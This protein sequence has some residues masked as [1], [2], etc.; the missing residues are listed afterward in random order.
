MPRVDPYDASAVIHPIARRDPAKVLLVED[1][2]TQLDMS[3]RALTRRGYDVT[4]VGSADAARAK[5]ESLTPDIILL[6][7]FLPKV[8]GFELLDELRANPRTQTTPI[9]LISG[10][11]DQ[12]HVVEGLDRGAN[13]YI[14]KPI[15][16]AILIARI[17]ALLRSRAL[18]RRLEVQTELLAKLAAF[19]EL[20]GV[21]NRRTLFHSLETEVSRSIRYRRAL[22]A[23]MLDVDHFKAINDRHGH[24]TG[25]AVLRELASRVHGAL[26]TMDVLG[27][28]GGEEFFVMLPETPLDG[29]A[30]AAERIRRA[31]AEKPFDVGA[32]AIEV[33]VSI[34]VASLDPGSPPPSGLLDEA[35]AALLEAKRQG[36][37]RVVMASAAGLR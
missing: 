2:R 15:S 27:R 36:R 32:H 5:L 13:D 1:S 25:D 17:E 6:D 3:R 4:G 34:G 14:G 12:E 22:S 35:D 33:T 20:T 7:I 11:T 30:R 28:Y 18:V 37:N 21:F 29:G 10:L 23:M 31:I 9:I 26:R 16:V 19:D 24:P 8:S